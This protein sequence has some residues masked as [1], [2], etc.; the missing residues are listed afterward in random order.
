[1]PSRSVG[2]ATLYSLASCLIIIVPMPPMCSLPRWRWSVPPRSK[3]DSIFCF[4]FTPVRRLSLRCST[5]RPQKVKNTSTSRPEAAAVVERIRVGHTRSR[6][7]L[8]QMTHILFW[9]AST[10]GSVIV[11]L[12]SSEYPAPCRAKKAGPLGRQLAA[13]SSSAGTR[14]L[15]RPGKHRSVCAPEAPH[16]VLV[17]EPPVVLERNGAV[18]EE[19]PLALEVDRPQPD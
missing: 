6:S 11:L 12:P 1:M 4:R 18:H 17:D 13:R 2:V 16:V 7:A 19:G 15:L 14:A 3:T 9:R 10:D 8:Q 5:R